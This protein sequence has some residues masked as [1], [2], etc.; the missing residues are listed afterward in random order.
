MLEKLS[1]FHFIPF[2]FF[3][4]G[5]FILILVSILREKMGLKE[6]IAACNSVN[7]QNMA[8]IVLAVGCLMVIECKLYGID[9]TASGSILGVGLNML[10][11]AAKLKI[12]PEKPALP[13]A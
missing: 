9:P 11:N 13:S 1:G 8:I 5:L 7:D 6:L 3:F 12:E 2:E 4:A 10:R